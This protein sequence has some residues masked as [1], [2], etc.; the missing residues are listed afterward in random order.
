MVAFMQLLC[1]SGVGELLSLSSK[2]G[3]PIPLTAGQACWYSRTQKSVLAIEAAPHSHGRCLSL[4]IH[5]TV[6]S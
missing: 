6:S 1:R 4:G 5:G 3:D 2:K